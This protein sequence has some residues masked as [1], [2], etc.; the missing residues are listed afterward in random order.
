[1]RLRVEMKLRKLVRRAEHN[2]PGLQAAIAELERGG[3]A[4]SEAL[5][6]L[7]VDPAEPW[8]K[9]R[10]VAALL[11]NTPATKDVWLS[12]VQF[13]E[14]AV[15]TNVVTAYI[16][17]WRDRKHIPHT[18]LRLFRKVVANGSSE[19]QRVA[20][21]RVAFIRTRS[22][23]RALI[24]IATDTAAPMAVR[25]CA[26]EMLHVHPSRETAE[27][28][29]KALDD[30]EASIRFWA[31]YALGEIPVFHDS[32]REL[33]VVLLQRALGDIRV[34]PG[35]WSVGREAQAAIA[36]LRGNDEQER[37]QAEIQSV[38]QDPNASTEDHRW[39]EYYRV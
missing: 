13:V 30:R 25:E 2:L 35:W 16:S 28:C 36:N 33:A 11:W 9:R 38:L 23:R 31:A 3:S 1:M 20:V 34:A 7:S 21:E 15:N 5:F 19:E 32:L 24:D 27:A 22:V 17:L 10:F 18:E 14:S 29:A 4:F 26:T 12:M 6:R 37:L 8:E 39:A